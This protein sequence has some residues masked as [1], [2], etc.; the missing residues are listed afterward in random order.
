MAL[1]VRTRFERT[2]KVIDHLWIP[3][4]DGT[5]L[6]GRVWL[7]VDAE[8][9]PVPAILEY[10]PY[11]KGDGTVTRDSEMHPY[12]AGHGYAAVRVD[13]RGSGESEGVLLDEYLT[14][15]QD[16]AV[17]VLAWLARQPWC[18]GT[19]GLI[20]KS[21]GG[22]NGLQIAARRPPQLAAV[23]SVCSTV[24]RYND[25]VHYIGG[26]VLAS[27]MLPWASTMLGFNA[28]PPDPDVVGDRWR[29]MWMDR[30]KGSPPFV[31]A[32]LTHQ[33]RDDYWK[34]G[35]IC[36]D[37]ASIA[38]PVYAVGGW[39]DGYSNAV[40]RL[41]EGLDVPRKG[42]IGP[43][44]HQY[45][46]AGNPGPAIG[47]LQ[48]CLH[49]WDHWLKGVDTGIMDEPML[50]VWMQGWDTPRPALETR[51]G[52]WV[53][54]PSWPS[55][56]A[57]KRSYVLDSHGLVETPSGDDSMVVDGS[58]LVGLEAGDWCPA[59]GPADLP[60]D[61]RAEDARS[62]CFDTPPLTH[63]L[64]ILGFP[65]VSLSLTASRPR[66]AVAV[67]LCDVAP[68]GTSLLVTRGVLNLSHVNSHEQPT[69][70]TP[71]KTFTAGATLNAIAHSVPKGHRL[72]L[73]VSCSYWPWVWPPPEKFC[74][75]LLTGGAS[76]LDLPVRTPRP[77]DAQLRPFADPEV[78]S[79]ATVSTPPDKADDKRL[80][81]HDL[82][83]GSVD[84]VRKS[85]EAKLLADT[86][87][88]KR[89]RRVETYSISPSDPLS[90]EV[91]TESTSTL[92]RGEW[93]VRVEAR[94]RLTAD[95]TSFHVTN[96]VEA[97]EGETRVFADSRTLSVPRDHC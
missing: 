45:P 33:R 84:V 5:R 56:R 31:E 78:S 14:Q 38:C 97:F 28:L 94:S 20:G 88:V 80:V 81:T 41:L 72:R 50:R 2:V 34:H 18:T 32:W 12:F 91:S 1:H 82:G 96:T 13:M 17:E 61:Q 49:W 69:D 10:I 42:L 29:T 43:W 77:E 62:L 23:V 46:H 58:Q 47:F 92:S 6:S 44:G 15:E 54:E 85:H 67:R 16:D 59:G 90:A 65:E 71:G 30:L 75:T 8:S 25:D 66:A 53:A 76:R 55:P 27:K 22:F 39:A 26:N 40:P 95:A 74:L 87:L 48:E 3:M 4:A 73:A 89:R 51:S 35:S 36:E 7:P 83:T 93:H 11:R 9:S 70:I 60:P 79:P 37:Y 21:W 24:D 64:D 86:G 52:R 19:V 57:R 63:P 68:D